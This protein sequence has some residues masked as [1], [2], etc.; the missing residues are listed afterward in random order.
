MAFGVYRWAYEH[1]VR[2]PHELSVVGFDNVPQATTIIPPLTTASFPYAEIIDHTVRLLM[3]K[4]EKRQISPGR[5]ILE[6]PL[7]VR[8]SVADLTQ[9]TK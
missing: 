8:H 9:S 2:I 1:R 4:L 7:I 6:M 5:M 3:A